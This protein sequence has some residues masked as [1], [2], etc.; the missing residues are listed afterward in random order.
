MFRTRAVTACLLAVLVAAPVVF[1]TP[2]RASRTGRLVLIAQGE[3]LD[4]YNPAN[5]KFFKGPD[6]LVKLTDWVNGTPCYIPGDPQGRFV[7]ADD[8]PKV[9]L[10]GV[11]DTFDG[12]ANPFWGIF[13]KD[14]SF[15]NTAIPSYVDGFGK[16][17]GLTDPAGCAFDAHGNFIG[18]DVGSNHTPTQGNGKVVMFFKDAGYQK[19]CVIA[20]KISQAGFPAFDHDGNLLVPATGEG[21]IYEYSH[22]PTASTDPCA[23]QRT[24]FMNG[25]ANGIGTPISIV[26]DPKDEGWTVGSV[27]APSGVFHVSDAGQV[28]GIVS[29]PIPTGGTP[30]GIC[31]DAAGNLYY[32]DLAVGPN[33]D[34]TDP[35]ETQ[36]D[37]GSLKWVPVGSLSANVP[38]V[39][40]VSLGSV[41]VAQT[42]PGTEGLNFADGVWVVPAAALP[43]S[44]SR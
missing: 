42:V 7:E 36:N 29:A 27:L 40:T 32:A 8:N 31:Y 14:G 21:M 9:S 26:R 11:S 20:D 39:G 4:V 12:D 28:D 18:S 5:G 35:I 19:Y 33:P 41:P 38:G 43:E 24:T 23:P 25:I 10:K 34:P 22:L 2:A 3:E 44:Y 30:F 15:T 1:L 37:A 13:S 6:A 16:D 17:L